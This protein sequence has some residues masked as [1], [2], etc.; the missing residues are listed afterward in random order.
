MIGE[1]VSGSLARFG[2]GNIGSGAL[3]AVEI[4][5]SMLWPGSESPRGNLRG[6]MIM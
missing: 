3:D 2:A 6:C 1:R 5:S 4:T